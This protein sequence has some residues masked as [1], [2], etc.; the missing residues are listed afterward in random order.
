ML[1][2]CVYSSL[3]PGKVNITDVI[4]GAVNLINQCSVMWNVSVIVTC[5][6]G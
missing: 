4:C 1:V 5:V 3:A 6:I 2:G